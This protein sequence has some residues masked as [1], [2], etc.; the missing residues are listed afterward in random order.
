M[1]VTEIQYT[2][3]MRNCNECSTKKDAVML[4][5]FIEYT[6]NF[7]LRFG[8]VIAIINDNHLSPGNNGTEKH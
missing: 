4:C 7:D 2:H 1:I 8:N 6:L 3:V 5:T